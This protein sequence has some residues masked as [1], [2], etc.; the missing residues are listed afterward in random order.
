M[1]EWRVIPARKMSLYDKLTLLMGKNDTPMSHVL[2]AA[3][4]HAG[5]YRHDLKLAVTL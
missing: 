1:E 5:S 2:K 3:E 4:L